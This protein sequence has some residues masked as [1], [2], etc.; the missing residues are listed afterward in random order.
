MVVNRLLPDF[1]EL[2]RRT[3]GPSIEVEN[4]VSRHPAVAECAIIGVPDEKW[5]ERVHAVVVLK[6]DETLDLAELSEH[7]RAEIAGYKTPRSLQILAEPLPRSAAGKVLKTELRAPWWEGQ[8]K[9]V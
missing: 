6:P 8:E 9:R 7:C 1:V 5:G 4:V 2:V 3:V